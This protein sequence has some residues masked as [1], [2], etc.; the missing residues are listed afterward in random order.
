MRVANPIVC[1]SVAVE[2]VEGCVRS[3]GGVYAAEG[4]C[5]P[6]YALKYKPKRIEI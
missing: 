3:K 1:A 5:G 2:M 4:E 6:I